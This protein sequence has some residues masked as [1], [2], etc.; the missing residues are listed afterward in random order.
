MIK[1]AINIRVKGN[2]YK[3]VRDLTTDTYGIGTQFYGYRGNARRKINLISSNNSFLNKD[4]GLKRNVNYS[5][6]SQINAE[7]A[8]TEHFV[9]FGLENNKPILFS[10]LFSSLNTI[11]GDRFDFIWEDYD[12]SQEGFYFVAK[13]KIPDT[14]ITIE[15]G[16]TGT[17]LFSSLPSFDSIG[18]LI[19][20]DNFFDQDDVAGK[21]LNDL[22]SFK[23]SL[24]D[25]TDIYLSF[26]EESTGAT[27][28]LIRESHDQKDALSIS[29]ILKSSVDNIHVHETIINVRENFVG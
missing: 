25:G 27:D 12:R 18:D 3:Y 6:K 19:A 16:T 21:I 1:A 20:S 7:M 26:P 23:T 29:Q 22:L 14:S 10:E 9:N 17:S 13:G 4:T 11:G 24:A 5:F 2:T 8:A 15:D 28:T